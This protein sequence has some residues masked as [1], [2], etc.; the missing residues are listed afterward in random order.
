MHQLLLGEKVIQT[1][2][3]VPQNLQ[4]P[5]WPELAVRKVF[6]EAIQ[7]PG[8]AERLPNEWTGNM[9]TDRNFFWS[10]V[11]GQH[12]RWVSMLLDNCTRQRRRRAAERQ[13]P[14]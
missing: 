12:E 7:L 3:E 10:T 2:S 6:P 11:V 4:I 5:N 13:M 1:Q 9:R 8:V 14:R